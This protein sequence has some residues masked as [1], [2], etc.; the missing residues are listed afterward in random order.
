MVAGE[1]RSLGPDYEQIV[2]M[3]EQNP[4]MFVIWAFDSKVGD[5]G[6]LTNVNLITE[7]VLTV[8]TVDDYLD[9]AVGQF[10][11]EFQVVE[12]ETL[13]IGDLPAG[14]LTIE[15]SVSGVN[16][17]EA[18]YVVKDGTTLWVIT[19]ATGMDEFDERWPVFQVS[20]Q[21]FAIQP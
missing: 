5:A 19:Y 20:A 8:I 12:R 14:R 16:G 4:G 3:I 17:K 2:Q 7:Q 21:T 1:L 15:F 11:A 10:P 9:A 13:S 18:L 6:F